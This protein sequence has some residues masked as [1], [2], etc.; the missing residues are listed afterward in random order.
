[1]IYIPKKFHSFLNTG[2]SSNPT[3]QAQQVIDDKNEEMEDSPSSASSELRKQ[4]PPA[5]EP[6]EETV[7]KTSK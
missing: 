3:S 7:Q 2:A 4:S 5:I 6:N 1:M